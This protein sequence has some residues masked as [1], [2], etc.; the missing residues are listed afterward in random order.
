M[1]NHVGDRAFCNRLDIK[2]NF[3][4]KVYNIENTNMEE[5]SETI[6]DTTYYYYYY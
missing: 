5:L 4:S 6:F 3:N 2:R 1:R